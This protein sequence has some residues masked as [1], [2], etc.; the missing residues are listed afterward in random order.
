MQPQVLPV[1]CGQH[2]SLKVQLKS[3]ANVYG[4]PE[5]FETSAVAEYLLGLLRID[6]SDVERWR[7]DEQIVLI[8]GKGAGEVYSNVALLVTTLRYDYQIV[9]DENLKALVSVCDLFY[10]VRGG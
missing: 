3:S 5:L 9:T 1:Q 7:Q 4:Q 10:D 2:P 8:Y 6:N